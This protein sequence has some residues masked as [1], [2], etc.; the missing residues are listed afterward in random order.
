MRCITRNA[1]LRPMTVRFPLTAQSFPPNLSNVRIR[2]VVLA[3]VRAEG[4]TF[5]IGN[6]RLMLTPSGESVA[7]GGMVGGTT[8]G[9]VSTRRGNASAWLPLVGRSVHGEWELTLPNT[10]EMRNRFKNEEIEDLLLILTYEGRTPAW[11]Q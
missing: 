5:E 8:D 7:V 3:A 1:P 6:T 11:P 10:Q 2:H 9:F 4:R